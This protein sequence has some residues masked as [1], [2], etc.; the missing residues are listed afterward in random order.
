MI[1]SV[2]QWTLLPNDHGGVDVTWITH[3]DPNGPLPAKM[4]NWLSV[5]PPHESISVLR[6]AIEG[7]EFSDAQMSYVV[8]P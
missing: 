3:T 1:E 7:G 6:A 8:E 4:V 2:Q 5:G